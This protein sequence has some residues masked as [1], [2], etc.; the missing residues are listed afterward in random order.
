MIKKFSLL[1]FIAFII[2][3]LSCATAIKATKAVALFVLEVD[4][5]LGKYN[6]LGY[7]TPIWLEEYKAAKKAAMSDWQPN[8]VEFLKLIKEYLDG[9]A[10]EGI[11]DG[12]ADILQPDGYRILMLARQALNDEDFSYLAK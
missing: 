11:E 4:K 1:I 9:K 5:Q 6:D 3:T 2:I 10:L 12:G 8:K 7:V